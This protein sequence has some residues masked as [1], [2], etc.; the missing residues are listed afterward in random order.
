LILATHDYPILGT[1]DYPIVEIRNIKQIPTSFKNHN[2]N[3]SGPRGFLELIL[4]DLILEFVC[5]SKEHLPR[6]L[7]Q[8]TKYIKRY[9]QTTMTRE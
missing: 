4:V 2:G 8:L 7:T 1:H 9:G 6:P 3:I 5:N